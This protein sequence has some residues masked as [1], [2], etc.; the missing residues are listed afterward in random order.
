MTNPETLIS[1]YAYGLGTVGR[2]MSA[3]LTGTA[4]AN[5]HL[6]IAGGE[7]LV[8]GAAFQHADADAEGADEHDR[9]SHRRISVLEIR[10]FEQGRKPSLFEMVVAGESFGDPSLTHDHERD[11]I[12]E[13]PVLVRTVGV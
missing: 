3:V 9:P 13:R 5:D 11:A 4:F 12:R 10:L 1:K 8:A 7:H 2:R 6:F